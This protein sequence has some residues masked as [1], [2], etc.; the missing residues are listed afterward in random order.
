MAPS[1]L[2]R[3]RAIK[4]LSENDVRVG[5]YLRRSTDDENQPYSIEVQDT[6]LLAYI[7]SQPGWRLVR[8]WSDPNPRVDVELILVPRR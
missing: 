2:A 4:T 5:I 1:S 6:R 7:A 8:R 3:R